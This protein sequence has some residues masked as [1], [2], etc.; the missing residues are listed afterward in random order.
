MVDGPEWLS[1]EE[2]SP[3][4]A[5]NVWRTAIGCF[6]YK[7]YRSRL[8]KGLDS[9]YYNGK[10]TRHPDWDRDDFS[11]DQYVMLVCAQFMFGDTKNAPFKWRL[12]RRYFNSP[13][14]FLWKKYL[15]TGKGI[16]GLLF[17][18]TMILNIALFRLMWFWNDN[19]KK[20]KDV[21]F[22][23]FHL[24]CW[25]FYTYRIKS[26]ENKYSFLHKLMDRYMID[27]EAR[28]SKGMSWQINY[29]LD[30]LING[31]NFNPTVLTPRPTGFPW[32]NLV[33][34]DK[35]KYR[36]HHEYSKAYWVKVPDRERCL[37][38]DIFNH[39]FS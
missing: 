10:Y 21:N 38:I 9:C 28:V 18:L 29:L 5:D 20:V 11:R 4:L 22:Y 26:S 15:D 16:Y 7:D 17:E 13:N 14:I 6:A 19:V 33:P 30:A 24:M 3:R 23:G 35:I 12:S 32:Q 2:Q 36:S 39:D 34:W 1:N 37:F 27:C 8:L 25:Q 31:E